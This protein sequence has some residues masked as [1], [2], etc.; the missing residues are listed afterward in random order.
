MSSLIRESTRSSRILRLVNTNEVFEQ[1]ERIESPLPKE[2]TFNDSDWKALEGIIDNELSSDRN[3]KPDDLNCNLDNLLELQ[4]ISIPMLNDD[5]VDDN[6]EET[7]PEVQNL[8]TNSVSP[9][10]AIAS[11]ASLITISECN[12]PVMTVSECES[13]SLV[14]KR[15]RK[16]TFKANPGK[17]R[18]CCKENWIDVKR[19]TAV[20]TGQQYV[21]RNGKV[22]QNK[23]MG[24]ICKSTC[25]LKC[26]E[27]FNEATRQKIHS[28]FWQ[29]ADH[30]KQWEFI[31]KF[32]KKLSK[33]RFTTESTSRRHFTTQYFLPISSESQNPHCEHRR[34][35]FKAFLNTLSITD[36]F[37]RTAHQKLN[38]E[39]ITLP[40]NRGKHPNHVIKI[41]SDMIKSVCDHVASFQPVESHY[42][43]KNT[44]KLYLDNNL[45]MKKMFSLYKEWDNLHLYNNTA[46]T[47]R[48]YTDIINEN[49][50]IAFFVPKKDLCDK[51]HSFSNEKFPTDE[52]INAHNIHMLNKSTARD[53]KSKDKILSQNSPEIVCATFDFQKILNCPHEPGHTQN[54]GDSVHA[55]IERESKGKM[56]YTPDQW[57][58]LVRWCKTNGTPY[59]VVEMTQD[60]FFDFKGSLDDRKWKKDIRNENVK[61]NSIKEISVCKEEPNSLNFKYNLTDNASCLNTK[62]ETRSRGRRRNVELK[63]SYTQQLPL[64]E[65][66]Y[67]DLIY[68]C[69]T[70]AIPKEY[71]RYFQSLKYSSTQSEDS[72]D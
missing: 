26:Y 40:D 3:L 52:Q 56:I 72:D 23:V 31:N 61:W 62:I 57:F 46:Q 65:A 19:K 18:K 21:S 49:I 53:L 25:K 43:R 33:R 51:C 68:L 10:M 7:Q 2:C 41:D 1:H 39:G 12:S 6:S 48:Q 34:V 32:S 35:C 5:D 36:Q 14:K 69:N 55:L 17:K 50:N 8:N 11:V 16:S 67:K 13:P 44:S 59:N 4:T 15:N 47:L 71:H 30:S 45:S 38:E 9:S 20:N 70:A 64:P 28:S 27:H 66:K 37:V 58:A 24:P 60:D 42:T 54:E 22:R 29:L 63:K